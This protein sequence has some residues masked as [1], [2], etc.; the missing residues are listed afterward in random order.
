MTLTSQD[1]AHFNTFVARKLAAGTAQSL[2][3]LA[4]EWEDERRD[5]ISDLQTA[6]ADMEAG[7]GRRLADFETEMRSKH[8]IPAGK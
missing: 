4:R 5:T 1:L 8:N 6:I 2:A 7:H 3:D